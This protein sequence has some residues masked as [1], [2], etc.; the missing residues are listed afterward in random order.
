MKFGKNMSR[1]GKKTIIIPIQVEVKIGQHQLEIKGP[2]GEL[3]QSIPPQLKLVLQGSVI[4]I[5]PEGK[6]KNISALWGLFRS[7]I[8]NMVKGV[9]EGFEKKL[10]IEGVGYRAAVQGNKLVLSIG[11]SHPVEIEAPANIEFKVEKNTITVSGIDKQVVGQIAA[12]IRDQRRPE[13]YKGKGIHYLGEIIRR[14]SGK[15]AVS[16]E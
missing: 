11:L 13:P 3:V 6:S 8:F 7:L 10:E 5:K 4:E 1:I 2:K 14:K 15:R 16:T 9:T 12:K